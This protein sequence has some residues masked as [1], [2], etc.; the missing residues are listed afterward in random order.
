MYATMIACA[1]ASCSKDDEVINGGETAKG[2]ATLDVKIATPLS[3]KADEDAE[4]DSTITTLGVYVFDNTYNLEGY[5]ISTQ[6]KTGTD[7]SRKVSGLTAGAKHVIV[8]ANYQPTVTTT[9]T[10]LSE[11]ES[12]VKEYS[13]ESMGN[14][15]MNSKVYDVDLQASVTNYL[16]Y[17]TNDVTDGGHLIPNDSKPV[18]LYRN[19]GKVVLTSITLDALDTKYKDAVLDVDSVFIL[20]AVNKSL[21]VGKG[22]AWGTTMPTTDYQFLNAVSGTTYEGWKS[23]ITSLT[24]PTLMQS[25]LVDPN[26]YVSDATTSLKDA[27]G[28]T[29][30]TNSLVKTNVDSFYVYENTNAKTKA[31]LLVVAG[32]L[33]Y[34]TITYPT[35]RYYSIAIGYDGNPDWSKATPTDGSRTASAGLY[36]NV[37]YNVA[38]TVKGPGYETPFGPEQKDN[39]VLDVK[40]KVAPFGVTSQNVEIE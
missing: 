12:N 17:I 24:N 9:T 3:T 18:Y 8:L 2:D 22:Y 26:S 34:G 11:F 35:T 6:G 40:V 13:T 28:F 33:K 5:T 29:L 21:A 37:Q 39:T 20:H 27:N 16:G 19:V 4:S 23:V 30:K 38:L 7:N 32:K 25:Y 1:F 15:S 14:F 31:T 10:T 36:R